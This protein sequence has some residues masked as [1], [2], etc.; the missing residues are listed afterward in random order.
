MDELIKCKCSI[1]PFFSLDGKETF[2][3]LVD[4]YDGDT[5]TCIIPLF[6]SFYKFQIRLNGIDTA[7]LKSKNLNSKHMA[8]DAKTRVVELT[9]NNSFDSTKINFKEYLENNPI[10]LW[11]K[12]Y[13]FDKYGR[14]LADVF[15]NKDD[16]ISISQILL[17]E[18]L[19]VAYDGKTKTLPS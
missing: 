18:H 1:T 6:N 2:C 19:A 7:E 4:I 14:L 5:M 10:I 8:I 16:N 11:I 12:C 13:K 15:L 17:N 3:K 9:S